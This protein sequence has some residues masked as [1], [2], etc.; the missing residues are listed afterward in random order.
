MHEWIKGGKLKAHRPGARF[1]RIRESEVDRRLSEQASTKPPGRG[2]AAVRAVPSM[3]E[4]C[5]PL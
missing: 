2:A 1:W 3:R 5:S 4:I